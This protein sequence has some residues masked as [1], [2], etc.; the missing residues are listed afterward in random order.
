MEIREL[1]KLLCQ[2]I[3]S[4]CKLL[5]PNGREVGN[6]YRV[7][8]IHGEAGDSLGV[9][10]GNDDKLGIW[11]D[12]SGKSGVKGGDLVDLWMHSRNPPITKREA[13]KEIKMYLNIQEPKLKE[14]PVPNFHNA[15]VKNPSAVMQYL[16]GER[17]LSADVVQRFRIE[18]VDSYKG[19]DW[20]Y[21]PSYKN[22]VLVRYKILAVQRQDGKKAPVLQPAGAMPCLFGWQSLTGNESSI[23]IDEGEINAMSLSHYGYPALAVPIG[24]GGGDKHR[25]VENEFDDLEIFDTI[26]IRA[27]NDKP[28]EDMIKELVTRLGRHRCRVLRFPFDPNECL[29]KGFT[30]AQID[31]LYAE[32]EYTH[33]E[34]ISTFTSLRDSIYK[35]FYR[36]PHEKCGFTPRFKKLQPDGYLQFPK[37]EFRY[38]ETTNLAGYNHEGKSQVVKQLLLDAVQQG[39]R[40]CYADLENPED[41]TGHRFVRTATTLRLPDDTVFNSCVN[42]LSSNAFIVGRHDGMSLDKI[43][44]IFLYLRRRFDVKIFALDSLMKIEGVVDDDNESQ[45]QAMNKIVDFDRKHRTHTILVSHFKKPQF[46]NG[47]VDFRH[48]PTRYQISGTA[49]LT[50]MPDNVILF[51]R[52]RL[53]EDVLSGKTSPPEGRSADSFMTEGDALFSID[54]QR[55]GEN[56]VGATS[57]W[58]EPES[59]QYL[60]KK[61]DDPFR[62]FK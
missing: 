55:H 33:P 46:G 13:V 28:G 41:S 44:E 43:H 19:K 52:N 30:K 58:W 18:G 7:G 59:M 21:F 9:H 54:K 22:D 40:V 51:F 15:I 34:E 56:W 31:K 1:N 6:E 5:L 26:Y 4:V 3:L 24:A 48:P 47:Y 23:T 27:D 62:Y 45:K 39:E 35:R 8:S 37:F 57:L 10:I 38:G 61:T 32:A 20:I 53:K 17:N 60:E 14:Y 12:F 25:W 49:H 11:T 16:T 2:D 36:D 29:Q 42:W 50:N